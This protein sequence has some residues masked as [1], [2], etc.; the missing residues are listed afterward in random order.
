MD[1]LATTGMTL[2]PAFFHCSMYL[3]GLPA[4][5]VT[6]GTFSSAITWAT[7]SA[8]GLISITLTPKG[9][10]VAARTTWICSRT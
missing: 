2:Q 5:V 9:L 3:E 7:S 6:T 4:P 1:T 8:K 10:S